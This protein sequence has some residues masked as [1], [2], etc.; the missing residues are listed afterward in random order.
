ME[1]TFELD[2]LQ[3]RIQLLEQENEQLRAEN[4]K[5]FSAVENS[6]AT[7]VISDRQGNIEYANPGFTEITGYTPQEVLGQHTRILKSGEHDGEF[8]K[9][10]W[11]T[12][13]SGKVWRGEFYNRKKNGEYYWEQ[14]H[15]AP[16]K[17]NKGEITHFVAI[18]FDISRKKESEQYL[19][20]IIN[21]IPDLIFVVDQ[22]GTFIDVMASDAILLRLAQQQLKGKS[23]N[24]IFPDAVASH[25]LELVHKTITHNTKQVLEYEIDSPSGPQWFEGRSAP[26]GIMVG[27]K[28]C[29][30]VAARDITYRKKTEQAL[31]ELNATKDKFFTILAH[32]LKNPF[33]AILTFSGMLPESITNRDLE[34]AIQISKLINSSAHHTYNLLENLLDWARSQTG[35]L[36]YHP[37]RMRLDELV[38]NTIGL[39]ESQAL[40][41]QVLLVNKIPEGT[42]VYADPN[43]LKTI[44]RNLVSNAIKFTG[45]AGKVKVQAAQ[46]DNF[47]EIVV[48]DT[49]V[50]ILPE[51]QEKIF[52][53]DSKFISKGTAEETGTGLGLILCREFVEKHGGKIWVESEV[54]KG[55]RFKFTLPLNSL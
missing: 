9:N 29:T 20:T 4:A 19:N 32:D 52:Q 40:G 27:G 41:K 13:V 39:L 7:I 55:S 3:K 31:K 49:G 42:D 33:G 28:K 1:I 34:E 51:V 25:L 23:L 36:V 10:L 6:P 44:I 54:G 37:E 17:N 14:A 50:G 22:E 35:K 38:N 5:F 47:M 24:K 15:I 8:Y 18:K 12:I 21:A 46:M 16:I 43:M 45:P 26:L 2:L 30:V 11:G 48:S 53:L